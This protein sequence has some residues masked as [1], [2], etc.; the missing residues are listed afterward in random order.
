M[1]LIGITLILLHFIAIADSYSGGAD[2]GACVSLA[3]GH[4]A[5]VQTST[6]PYSITSSSTSYSNGQTVTVTISASPVQFKGILLQARRTNGNTTPVGTWQTP[7]I[8]FKFL[9]CSAPGDSITHS[10]SDLKAT[11]SFVWVA[12]STGNE[13]IQ[14]V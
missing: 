13:D 11:V 9:Q 4:G 1:E 2:P 6:S 10:N 12:P 7:P 8:G 14:F 5:E 3:P